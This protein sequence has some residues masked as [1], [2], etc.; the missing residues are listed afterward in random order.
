M[1]DDRGSGR[2][3]GPAGAGPPDAALKPWG[4]ARP[5]TVRDLGGDL[6]TARPDRTRC[7]GCRRTHVVLDVGLLPRR[8]YTVRF[9]GRAL[10]GAV[11]G[12]GHRKIAAALGA[13]EGT[14]RGWLRRARRTA[15]QLRATDAVSGCCLP[16]R[17]RR[18]GRTTIRTHDGQPPTHLCDT[19]PT[20]LSDSSESSSAS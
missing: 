3:G 20:S 17:R 2:D 16:I 7:T 9:L 11:R 10:V 14:V 4:Q 8:A 1:D 15:E 6:V 18:G 12:H 5:R 13:P 19:L